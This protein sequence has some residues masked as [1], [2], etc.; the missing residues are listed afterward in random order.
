[1][2]V[3]ALLYLIGT[4]PDV[5]YGNDTYKLNLKDYNYK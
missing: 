4:R 2:V 1:M 3:S 5:A